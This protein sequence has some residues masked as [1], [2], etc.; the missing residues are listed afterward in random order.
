MG[1]IEV[2]YAVDP[3]SSLKEGKTVIVL[4]GPEEDEGRTVVDMNDEILHQ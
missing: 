1:V 2:L 3:A 4:L